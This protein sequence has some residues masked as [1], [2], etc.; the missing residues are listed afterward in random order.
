MAHSPHRQWK[1]CPLCKMHK[2]K[3]NGDAE[4]APWAVRRQLGM[5][6]RMSRHDSAE[7]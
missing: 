4:R 2:H 3:G 1:G 5:K 7:R 6:R